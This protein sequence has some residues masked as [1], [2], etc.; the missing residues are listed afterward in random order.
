MSAWS[1]AEDRERRAE[2]DIRLAAWLAE[3][4]ADIRDERIAELEAEVERL[5]AGIED[6]EVKADD[7]GQQTL[8]NMAH[9]LLN[10]TEGEDR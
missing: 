3:R 2:H 9:A 7:Y 10:P 8:M 4:R 1:D 5:R 6:I